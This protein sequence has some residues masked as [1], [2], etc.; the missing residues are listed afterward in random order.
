MLNARKA[1]LHAEFYGP[2]HAV[3]F[4]AVSLNVS[5]DIH[6]SDGDL[7][8]A[9]REYR[10]G[11]ECAPQDVNLLNSLG[12]TY[13]L[14]NKNNLARSAFERVIHADPNNYMA[15]YN[16]GLGAKVQGDIQGAVQLFERAYRGC[17][18]EDDKD[19]YNFV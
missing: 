12:V 10:R 18:V 11:L 1:L 15:L 4:D 13:A 17:S 8:G 16:L 14:L 9:L 3:Q 5:G 7:A 2:G 19:S 6:F